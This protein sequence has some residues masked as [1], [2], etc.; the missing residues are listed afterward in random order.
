MAEGDGGGKMSFLES[1]ALLLKNNAEVVLKG[2]EARRVS[3]TGAL[4]RPSLSGL[5]GTMLEL[6]KKQKQTAP[7]TKRLRPSRLQLRD[8]AYGGCEDSFASRCS[9]KV[10]YGRLR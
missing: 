3:G 2:P 8:L 7:V 6:A 10:R 1:L 9:G 5:R 4:S